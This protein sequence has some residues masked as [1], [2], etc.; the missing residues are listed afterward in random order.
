[1]AE[2]TNNIPVV[3]TDVAI[4]TIVALYANGK[5]P[6]MLWGPPGIGKTALVYQAAKVI[7]GEVVDFRLVTTEPTDLRGYPFMYEQDNGKKAMGWA[8]AGMLPEDPNWKGFVFLDE[9][10]QAPTMN[11]NAAAELVYDRRLGNDYVLPAGAMVIAAGNRRSDRAG[12]IEVPTHMKNRLIHMEV[13]ADA[14]VWAAWAKKEGLHAGLID[15]IENN[16]TLFNDFKADALAFPTPR[17][18]HFVSDFLNDDTLAGP[19]RLAMLGGAVGKGAAAQLDNHLKRGRGIPTYEEIIK[20]PKGA[21]VGSNESE[22]FALCSLIRNKATFEDLDAVCIYL[23]RHRREAIRPAV[24]R[25]A[26]KNPEFFDNANF[27]ALAAGVG[28]GTKQA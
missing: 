4:D 21:S 2:Q 14:Q 27:R 23:A 24:H 19:V 3:T 8:P 18:W 17:T 22:A 20:D 13:K 11:M 7:G 25:M 9:L 5:H 16:P 26:G 28:E 15:F 10:P 6:A 12:T 1:M